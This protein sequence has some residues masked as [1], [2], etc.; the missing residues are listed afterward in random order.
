ML[1]R[2]LTCVLLLAVTGL[3]G[4][5]GNRESTDPTSLPPLSESDLEKIKA[6]DDEVEAEEKGGMV[7]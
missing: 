4:C 1:R 6:Y 7:N 2:C 5:G 3:V